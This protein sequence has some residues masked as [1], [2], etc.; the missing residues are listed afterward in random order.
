MTSHADRRP[1]GRSGRYV[2]GRRHR[3]RRDV[4]GPPRAR[5]RHRRRG[6]REGGP[7]RARTSPRGCAP[8]CARPGASTTR[9][10]SRCAT[11]ARTASASTWCG[12]W[13]RG[14]S[15]A[16]GAARPAA[17]R[18]RRRPCA[19]ARTCCA[20]LAHAHERG[21][22]HRDV[23]PAN[24]LIGPDGRARLSD[25]GVARL[26]GESG[27]TMTG[28]VVGTVA[29]M[30]PEQ[31]RGEGAGPAADVYSACLVLY[32]APDRREPGAGVQPGRDRPA[33]RRRRRAA[34][35]AG[36]RPTCPRAS[37]RR[38][39]P[40][41]AAT[42]RPAPAGGRAGRRPGA[43]RG[44]RAR[45]PAPRRRARCR[46]WRARPG[47]RRWPAWRCTMADGQSAGTSS[48]DWP[49]R[50]A[51]AAAVIA[52]GRSPS[53]GARAAA[54]LVAVRRRRRPG[55]PLAPPAAAAILGALALLIARHRLALRAPD[56]ARRR[57]RRPL[58]A[59]GL[60]PLCPALA[61]LVP[62]WPARLWAAAAGMVAARRLAG[63]P[64]GATPCWP[65]AASLRVG[66]RRPATTSARRRSRPSASGSPLADRPEARRA[67]R[68]AGRRRHV[69]ARWS[70]GRAP[71]GPRAG[72]ARLAGRRARRR[73]W[74]PPRADAADAAAAP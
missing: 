46:R 7:G 34:A 23:K 35:G 11:G 66:R 53:P 10:S 71:G 44:R 3:P 5:P 15:L 65:A 24:I 32:E 28:G 47:A 29:Y 17:A 27:L 39:T 13:S 50:P 6:G 48:A 51:V 74:W 63:R 72:R 4:G 16:R 31:A 38:S 54:A 41:S 69:R 61:G 55:G 14:R 37:A 22:V 2:L 45:G 19:S 62:R 1:H 58:F 8:R 20:A 52:V 56:P 67:G 68:R 30:A 59:V 73:R 9:G 64:P 60:G 42:P 18:R 43:R 70:C 57:R 12:S 26:S 33:R 49:L 36:A 40:A 25:F 21:V